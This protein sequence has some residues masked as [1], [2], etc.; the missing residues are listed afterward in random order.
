MHIVTRDEWGARAPK[1]RHY[2]DTPSAEL[3]LHHTAGALDAGG[4]GVWWDDMRGIQRFHMDGRGWADIAY[5]FLVAD[6]RVWEGRGVGVQG[7]HTRGRNSVSHAVC[8]VGHYDHMEPTERDIDA[9]VELV[10]H[11]RERGWWGELTGPHRDAPGAATSCCGS[12]L[13]ARI[14]EIRRR[15]NGGAKPSRP[16]PKPTPKPKPT[17]WTESLIMSLPLVRKGSRGANVRRVQALLTAN[18]HR[19]A[20]D[21]IAGPKTD[22]AIRAFQ[23]SAK[24]AVD[25][26]VGRN[27]WT[28]LLGQ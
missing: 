28:R 8:V 23:R 13:I 21:G 1:Y 11:G 9:V 3:W 5:S 6:G 19:V 10:A 4:N 18:G 17:D 24:L 2:I 12:H 7:G 20:I 14:P 22:A 27:T 25:G 16:T 15:A 26:I